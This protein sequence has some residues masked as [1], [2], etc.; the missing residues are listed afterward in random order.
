MWERLKVLSFNHQIPKAEQDSALPDKLLLEAD[1]ILNWLV[2]GWLAYQAEGRLI[3]P[4]RVAKDSAV[5]RKEM[6]LTAMFIDERCE[7]GEDLRDS[8]ADVF[9]EYQCWTETVGV[10]SLGRTSFYERMN[11]AGHKI[12]KYRLGTKNPISTIIGLR[13]IRPL[14]S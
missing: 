11:D 9:V 14:F 8:S 2:Q 7:V 1:G 13:L 12:E 4:Q 6:D 5:Y 3:E 10:K